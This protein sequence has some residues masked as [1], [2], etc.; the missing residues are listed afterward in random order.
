MIKKGDSYYPAEDFRK[1]AW[2]NDEKIYQT[3]GKDPIKFWEKLANELSWQKKWDKVFEHN[4]PYFKWFAGGKLNI[5]ENCLDKNLKENGNKTALIWEPEPVEEKCRTLTYQQLFQDVNKFSNGLLKLGIKKGDKVGIYLPMIPEIIISMLACARIGAIHSVVFSAFSPTALKVRLEDTEAKILITADGYFR[6]G[7]IVN[8]KS[9]ADEAVKETKVEKVIVVKR[10]ANPVN[11]QENRDLWYEDLV[12][13]EKDFCEPVPRDSEDELFILYTSGSTGKPKGIVH[14]SGG[15]AVQSKFTGKWIF[16]WK[17]TDIFWSTSDMGWI[18]GHTY[19]CYAPLLNGITFLIFEGAPDFPT[20]ERWA[21]IIEKH[22]ITIFYTAPTAIRMFEKYGTEILKK[23]SFESLRL[24]GS[25]GEP[26]DEA[27]WL[28]YF[29]NVGKKKCPIVDT[30]WQTETGGILITSLPGMGP[31]KPSFAGIPFPG[32]KF[33]ILDDKGKSCPF[34]KEG[35]LVLLS[36]FSPGLLRGV[37]KNPE[38][39]LKTYWSQYAAFQADNDELRPASSGR[40]KE[41]YFTSD[42]AIK[43]EKGLIRIVGRVDDVIK[44]AG[45]RI[46]T[47]ELES[48]INSHPETS[49]SAVV[50]IPDEIKGEV[51]LAFVSYKGEKNPEELK[52]EIINQIKKE[53]G[54]VA[55]PKEIYLVEDLPKTRSGKIMRRILKK[56][57]TGEEL[58]DLSTLS[59]AESVEKIK[60]IIKKH[61]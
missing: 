35:N 34:K 59:N 24:L 28:W 43:D 9:N 42:A 31:F 18:T 10:T 11:W 46:T 50:G 30:W 6:K 7:R 47:G 60:S 38:K 48:A 22:K 39:Y 26:I 1:Q 14:T 61:G 8:L 19:S 37:Y 41:V 51:P 17:E 54:P 12:K 40:G 32:I 15:Y 21:Q 55:L 13:D 25:V 20:P 36:P 57:F 49:E 33:D 2:I 45:H 53:I 58:G 44:V 4:P 27:A 52:K 56:L 5:T 23:Y 16:D 29:E 3:A